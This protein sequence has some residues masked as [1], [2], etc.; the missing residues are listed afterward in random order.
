MLWSGIGKPY[1]PRTGEGVVG[2]NYGYQIGGG[3]NVFFDERTIMNPFL[4][5]GAMATGIDDFNGDNF[6][7]LKFGFI[8]GGGILFSSPRG[9]T[10]Q[11]PP[12]PTG[13]PPQGDDLQRA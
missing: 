11:Y 13:T 4:G 2:R 9:R 8:G 12:L 1:D 6:D 5:A 10:I 3:A 7:H